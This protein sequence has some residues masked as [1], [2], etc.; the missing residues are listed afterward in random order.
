MSSSAFSPE[1]EDPGS[2]FRDAQHPQDRRRRRSS[3]P[4]ECAERSTRWPSPQVA[5]RA[6]HPD[7]GS[8]EDHREHLPRGQH[9]A[10]E[11][12][13][14]RLHADGHRRLGRDRRGQDQAVR[15]HAVLS[16]AGA[17]RALHSD[18]SVLSVLARASSSN[19]DTRFI[20]LAGEVNR[21]MP[22][23]VVDALA[24]ALERRSGKPLKGANI[25]RHGRGVQEERRRP[26]REPG[27]RDHGDHPGTRRR[28]S[29]ITIPISPRSCRR[30]ST[31]RCKACRA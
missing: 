13:E 24:E 4:G 14:D 16:G 25:L 22:Q 29:P 26:A 27:A 28:P 19:V 23:L 3:A 1:R 31:R 11:R 5:P 17:R 10:R 21:A 7:G 30:A 18:R 9:R 6:R 12:A 8:G 20:E 15:L 2:G